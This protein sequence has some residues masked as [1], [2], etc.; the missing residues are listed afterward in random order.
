ME[1]LLTCARTQLAPG[2]AEQLRGL[3]EAGISWPRLCELSRRH[4]LTP[5]L[6][7][8]LLGAAADLIPAKSMKRLRTKF[9]EHAGHNLTLF[10]EL[11][12]VLRLFQEHGIPAVP[13][14]GPALAMSAYGNV[15]LREYRDLDVLVRPRD[16]PLVRRLLAERGYARSGPP[17][18][19]A[20]AQAARL[21][22]SCDDEFTRAEDGLR[23]EV[24][25]RLFHRYFSL[26]LEDSCWKR[27]HRITL[28]ERKTLAFSAEDE[29]LMLC[30]HG[31]KHCWERLAWVSDVAEHLRT[32][33][34]LDWAYVFGQARAMRAERML[35]LGLRLATDLL[36]VTL[37]AEAHGRVAGDRAV[38][39]LAARVVARSLG[40]AMGPMREPRKA[41]FQLSCR[42]GW[43]DR[44]RYLALR[45]VN[46]NDRDWTLVPLPSAL[47]VLYY[48]LR[49]LRVI[50]QLF[51]RDRARPM[52]QGPTPA[53]R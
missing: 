12:D 44:A 2:G 50:V 18:E 37:P 13:F 53:A 40:G 51:L 16:V 1:L 31:A 48:P 26:P 46:L 42:D 19:T 29:L 9:Y 45:A 52:P 47:R 3:L 24:H 23:L 36:D 27:T 25:W 33:P 30:A 20:A 34:D 38:R 35:R 8:H 15:M 5:L 32:Q 49:A 22:W 17:E 6:Y 14:K 21:E 4:G 41:L 10:A 7:R 39:A 28:G 43:R 11:L